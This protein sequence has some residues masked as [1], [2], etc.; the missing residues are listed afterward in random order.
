MRLLTQPNDS[1]EINLTPLIDVVFLM[2]IFFVLT[3]TFTPTRQLSVDLPSV[4]AAEALEREVIRVAIRANGTVWINQRRIN[5][6]APLA[7]RDA[8]FAA[9]GIAGDRSVRVLIEAD[10]SARHGRVTQI[11]SAARQLGI[12]QVSIATTENS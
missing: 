6:D 8:L 7:L 5:P 4:K 12:E 1:P 10:A 2:L 3:T 11:L 9:A